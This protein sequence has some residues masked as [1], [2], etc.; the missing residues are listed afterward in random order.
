M[1]TA[2]EVV[3]ADPFTKSISLQLGVTVEDEVNEI[4][5]PPWIKQSSLFLRA[6]IINHPKGYSS[7]MKYNEKDTLNIKL[8]LNIYLEE[9][10]PKSGAG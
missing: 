4:Y 9:R 10:M 2:V 1:R 3:H 7:G 5:Y 6:Y 8:K